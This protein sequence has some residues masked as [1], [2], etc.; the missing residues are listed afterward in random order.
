MGDKLQIHGINVGSKVL[1]LQDDYTSFQIGKW[2]QGFEEAKNK[3]FIFFL[4]GSKGT[5]KEMQDTT[6]TVEFS[7]EECILNNKALWHHG[8]GNRQGIWYRELP[9]LG[10]NIPVEKLR[11]EDEVITDAAPD[12]TATPVAAPIPATVAAPDGELQI[13]SIDVDSEV[14]LLQDHT[15][16][17]LMKHPGFEKATQEDFIFFPKGTTGTVKEMQYT[18]ATVEF[19]KGE[20]FLNNKDRIRRRWKTIPRGK[21]FPETFSFNIPVEKLSLKNE[22][23]TAA[24]PDATATPVAAPGPIPANR[25]TAYTEAD[26]PHKFILNELINGSG[27][28]MGVRVVEAKRKFDDDDAVETFIDGIKEGLQGPD[29]PKCPE[30]DYFWV[31]SRTECDYMASNDVQTSKFCS[32][33]VTSAKRDIL[34]KQF[35]Y[36]YP[37]YTMTKVDA[38][39]GHKPKHLLIC[40][41]KDYDDL[42]EHGKLL[43]THNGDSVDSLYITGGGKSSK[44]NNRKLS[45][46]KK[47][48]RRSKNKSRRS[49]NK[50]RRSKHKSRRRKK[51]NYLSVKQT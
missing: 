48:T 28:W 27:K 13:S 24:A 6:A 21:S 19:S 9:L 20:C 51:N 32:R 26:E 8:I 23:I 43:Y 2:P 37:N 4:K 3:D 16:S 44:R 45:R 5:V 41:T 29:M 1:L 36:S 47:Q 35:L 25:S 17:E 40:L 22:V 42:V 14:L 49:K 34:I 30:L 33:S 50:S 39:T 46:K 15:E 18:T 7:K 11:L 12:A 38:F 10:F 31:P